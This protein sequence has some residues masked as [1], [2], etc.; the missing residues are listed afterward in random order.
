MKHESKPDDKYAKIGS[1]E[2]HVGG[3]GGGTARDLSVINA[4]ELWNK[5]SEILSFST[6]VEHEVTREDSWLFMR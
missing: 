6:L 4:S 3:G 2:L 5:N 1:N